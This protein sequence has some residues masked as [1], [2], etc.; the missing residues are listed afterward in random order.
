[1][2]KYLVLCML[3]LLAGCGSSG[4]S[5]RD[6]PADDD[7]YTQDDLDKETEGVYRPK[8]NGIDDDGVEKGTREK[9]ARE[10][11][12]EP[13]EEPAKQ[14]PK[15]EPKKEEPKK[16]PG[17]TAEKPKEEPKKEPPKTEPTKKEPKK[18]D[19]T[20]LMAVFIG[21][22]SRR[23]DALEETK[24]WK[25]FLKAKEKFDDRVDK[26][27]EKK[28]NDKGKDAE[29]AWANAIVA[30]YEVRFM[31]ELLLHMNWKA[32]REF[33][34]GSGLTFTELES[35]SDTELKSADCAQ[36]KAA[37]ELAEPEMKEVRQFQTDV[38]KYDLVA[39][40]VYVDPKQEK[41]WSAEKQKWQDATEGKFDESDLKKYR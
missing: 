32:T 15:E 39:S 26:G 24:L 29:E 11:V 41:K 25:D 8:N 36:T 22:V 30:W 7:H 31:Y 27:M 38:L 2:N 6:E 13:K 4:S 37:F 5:Q 1:M 9:P 21:D 35:Y 14:P 3:S 33:E 40:K 12:G 18:V 34:P 10:T 16:E 17:P 23:M 19:R 28:N 20:E